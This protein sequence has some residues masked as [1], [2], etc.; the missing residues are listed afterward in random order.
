M[1]TVS[2]LVPKF[3]PDGGFPLQIYTVGRFS[4]NFSTAQNFRGE[5]TAFM[6]PAMM[7]QQ[8]LRRA[9]VYDMY[10]ASS[11]EWL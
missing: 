7:L 5:G 3:F 10:V 11:V 4:N 2:L 1:L 8:H 6:P 9:V